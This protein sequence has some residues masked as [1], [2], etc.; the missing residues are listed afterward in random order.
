[1]NV[2]N[3]FYVKGKISKLSKGFLNLLQMEMNEPS[4][5]IY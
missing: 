4:I 5:E 2:R 1:M 3:M